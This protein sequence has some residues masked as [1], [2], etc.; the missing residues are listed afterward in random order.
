MFWPL[1]LLLVFYIRNMIDSP[2]E[3]TF[4]PPNQSPFVG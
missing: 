4:A 2:H 3:D 1:V